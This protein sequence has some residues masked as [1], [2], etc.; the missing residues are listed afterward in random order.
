M[1]PILLFVSTHDAIALK[2]GV[3]S[4]LRIWSESQYAFITVA[5]IL[6]PLEQFQ[7]HL[8]VWT[9]V[10]KSITFLAVLIESEWSLTIEF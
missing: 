3:D 1:E 9:A 5:Q 8:Q 10:I 7:T 6:F 4:S 2:V